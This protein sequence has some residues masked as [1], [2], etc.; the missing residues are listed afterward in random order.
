MPSVAA[1]MAVAKLLSEKLNINTPD[2]YRGNLLPD[3]L[4]G[5]MVDS[6]FKVQGEHFL[7]TDVDEAKKNLVLTND[8]DLGYYTHLLLDK[9]FL[10]EFVPTYIKRYDLFKTKEM[11]IDYD[12]INFDI[13]DYFGLDVENLSDVLTEKYNFEIDEKKLETN[14]RCLNNKKIGEGKYLKKE[15]FK[16]FLI[17]ASDRIY[18]EVKSYESKPS[19]P[20]VYF[21]Q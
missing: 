16:K 6:H 13:V 5:S 20:Y 21:K 3:I 9:L 14:I 11:Y 17:E 4:A 12:L 1:H 19:V 18:E 15:E 7:V 2:F 8:L 10:E